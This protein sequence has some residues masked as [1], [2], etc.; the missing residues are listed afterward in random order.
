MK[1]TELDAVP[2]FSWTLVSVS[3]ESSQCGM[4]PQSHASTSLSAI[5]TVS[6]LARVREKRARQ[7]CR[8]HKDK[9]K[10]RGRERVGYWR[11][12]RANCEL[13]KWLA[14]WTFSL[15]STEKLDN[16]THTA[17]SARF[18][19]FELSAG[20]PVSYSCGPSLEHRGLAKKDI[21]H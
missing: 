1:K 5:S 14:G 2:Q 13:L 7:T 10:T 11:C 16:L 18:V 21:T 15:V 3:K 20:A 4:W 6:R 12:E 17:I 19:Y 9:S 8:L